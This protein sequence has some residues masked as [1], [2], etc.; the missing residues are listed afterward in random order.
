MLRFL[1]ACAALLALLPAPLHAAAPPFPPPDYA[2]ARALAVATPTANPYVFSGGTF[3]DIT[4]ALPPEVKARLGLGEARTTVYDSGLLRPVKKPT[5][6]GPYLA[7]VDIEDG[8]G[9]VH[10]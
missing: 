3:P 10:R 7:V 5:A 9:R 1:S 2:R 8:A 4:L 6:P